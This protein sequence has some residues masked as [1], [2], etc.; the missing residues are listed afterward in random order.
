MVL[1]WFCHGFAAVL[2]W[3]RYGYVWNRLPQMWPSPT[4]YPPT[5]SLSTDNTTH[6]PTHPT[7]THLNGQKD[8]RTDDGHTNRLQTGW[9]EKRNTGYGWND[10]QAGR[11]MDRRDR[12][13][14]RRDRRADRQTDRQTEEWPDARPTM[15][16]T[17]GG[18]PGKNIFL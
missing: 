8:G 14:D 10:R 11:R 18:R 4:A 9:T 3:F 2:L 13:I 1:P 15:T 16:S 17:T 7:A 5:N 6:P 12:Q